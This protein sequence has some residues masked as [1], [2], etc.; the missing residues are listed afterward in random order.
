MPARTADKS[1]ARPASRTAGRTK[2]KAPAKAKTALAKTAAKPRAAKAD[3]PGTTAAARSRRA[4]PAPVVDWQAA[5]RRQHAREQRFRLE[6]LGSEPV[7]SDYRVHAPAGGDSH[8]VSIRGREPGQNACDCAGFAA[9]PLGTCAHIE[10]TLAKLESR[11]GAKA[12]LLRGFQ[13]PYSEIGIDHAGPRQLRWRAGTA[14]PP[15]LQ[16]QARRVFDAQ[17]GWRLPLDAAERRDRLHELLRTAHESGH[18]LRCDDAVWLLVAQVRD[19][20]QRSAVL[21]QAYPDGPRSA[22]LAGLLQLPLYP[23]QAEGALFAARAGRALIADEAGLGKTIQAIAAAELLARHFGVQR[24]LVA[25]PASMQHPWRSEFARCLPGRAV[26][27]VH[28]PR[29]R[30]Q[31]QYRDEAFCR[32][33]SCESLAA[34]RD[35]VE[36]W[37]PD[38]VI[39]DDAQRLRDW[40]GPAGS[41]LRRIASPY[42][43][44]LTGTALEYRP[45]DLVPALEFIDPHRLGPARQLQQEHQLRDE[46]GHVTGY[47][48]LER[49]DQTLA[50]ALLRR[51][52]ADVLDQLPARLEL[53]LAVPLAHGQREHHD[54]HGAI[55]R[56][57]V[58]RWRQTGHLSHTGQRQLRRALQQMRLAAGSA[59]LLDPE[60]DPGPKVDELAT[61][62]DE[63]LE[64][65]AAKAVVFCQWPGMHRLIAPRLTGHGWGHVLL[66]G[67]AAPDHAAA[68]VARFREDPGCRV[69]LAT[70]AGAAGLDL[71]QDDAAV[72]NL[73]RP[74]D[75]AVLEQRFRRVQRAGRAPGALVVQFAGQASI[76]DGLLALPACAS[77]AAAGVLDG[78]EHEVFL[79]GQ[80]LRQFMETAE[81]VIAAMGDTAAQELADDGAEAR[82]GRAA[83]PQARDT[84]PAAAQ[85]A[86]TSSSAGED[87]WVLPTD[88]WLALLEAGSTLLQG[89]TD[90]H[91]GAAPLAIQ[92]DPSTGQPRLTLPLPDPGMLRRLALALQ[93]W[94]ER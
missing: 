65:P 17:D 83:R 42:A 76:E 3:P 89:L 11:R 44:V 31:Q 77:P 46:A 62:L 2:A 88:A 23:Y 93:P 21:A 51:R 67:S 27:V 82:P 72:V 80:R 56:R 34:D 60:A 24:V 55:A 70:D 92:Q 13:P 90:G 48:G 1:T 6:N 35:L 85:I 18:D 94:L 57:I 87:A 22:G 4:P 49:I 9:H 58:Q 45:E 52:R 30:R 61:L 39:A 50:A 54:R 28:G 16:K 68:L 78:G 74:W 25:C 47:H 33:V 53:R 63:L 71:Q 12:A 75:P 20:E 5:L 29:A 10:F 69:L 26:Q 79:D 84:A 73:D 64:A 15:E 91:A 14:C 7:F 66:D 59:A 38:L 37:G 8:R 41:A 86:A 36:A 19:A 43:L 32:I 40:S 81:Q